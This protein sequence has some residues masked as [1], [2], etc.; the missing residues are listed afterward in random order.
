M[1]DVL[2]IYIYDYIF[3][4]VLILKTPVNVPSDYVV[5]TKKKL[6]IVICSLTIVNKIYFS[7]STH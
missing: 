2:Y 3:K 7:L 1:S 5:N 6:K 4:N